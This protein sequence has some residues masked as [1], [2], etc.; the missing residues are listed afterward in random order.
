[1][2]IKATRSKALNAPSGSGDLQI[3]KLV[4]TGSQVKQGDVVAQ[5]DTTTLQR[6]L[7]QKQSDLKTADAEIERQRAQ[8]HMTEEQNITDS[9]SAKYNVEK[10]KLDANKQEILSA[11]DGE[12]T[13]L[14]V[15]DS[16]K[17]LQETEVKL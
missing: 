1:G 6:T 12:K 14:A 5:F 17:K 4:K 16:E 11:I 3:L 9:L 2:E 10:T 13:Q 15:S 7:E 8:G